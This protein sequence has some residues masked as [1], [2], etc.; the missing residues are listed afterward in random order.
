MKCA[1]YILGEGRLTTTGR[2]GF[3]NVGV[4]LREGSDGGEFE[5]EALLTE[6][7]RRGVRSAALT[8]VV[9]DAEDGGTISVPGPR[10]RA[11]YERYDGPEL[12]G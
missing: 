10:L 11:R 9:V 7:S 8:V 1:K 12:L 6:G 2:T 3:D 5:S 4:A